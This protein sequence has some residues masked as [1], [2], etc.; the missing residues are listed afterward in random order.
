MLPV[1]GRCHVRG[2]GIGR[3][4][5]V[6][7]DKPNGG[8]GLSYCVRLN[9]EPNKL[10][11]FDQFKVNYYDGPDTKEDKNQTKTTSEDQDYA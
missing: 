3:I 5:A 10:Q 7:N 9:K 6:C 2:Y 4:E 11:W 1:Y 8:V